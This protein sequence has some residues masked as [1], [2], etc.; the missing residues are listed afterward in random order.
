[1]VRP[2]PLNPRWVADWSA[3]RVFDSG[4]EG[5][6]LWL[7]QSHL[8]GPSWELTS[9]PLTPPKMGTGWRLTAWIEWDHAARAIGEATSRHESRHLAHARLVDV[10]S[11]A[12][13]APV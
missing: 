1:V 10:I 5:L 3:R 4:G 12:L 11:E 2:E 8:A 7:R 9:G 13:A 6:A